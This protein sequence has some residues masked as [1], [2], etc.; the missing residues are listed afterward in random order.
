MATL[1]VVAVGQRTGQRFPILKPHTCFKDAE[2]HRTMCAATFPDEVYEVDI[3]RA[4]NTWREGITGDDL[5]YPSEEIDEVRQQAGRMVNLRT[6][7]G[8][9]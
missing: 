1:Q 4:N 5:G 8:R 2:F 3:L 7:K 6:P 9:R